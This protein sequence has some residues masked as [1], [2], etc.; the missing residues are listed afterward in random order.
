MQLTFVGTGG[1]RFTT[2]KQLRR[3]GGMHLEHDDFSLYIDPGP[4]ALVHA[5]D[6]DIALDA[7]DALLVTHAHL[8]HCND[9]NVLIEAMTDGGDREQGRLL[10][11]RT[12]IEGADLPD[13]FAKGDGTYGARIEPVLD[14]FHRGL[15][16]TV[17][18]VADGGRYDLGP[19]TVHTREMRHSDPHSI[20]FTLTADD[21]N[22]GFTGDTELFDGLIEFFRDCDVL[23]CNLMRP[24]EH[25][26]KGHLTTEDAAELLNAVEPDYAIMQ[27]FGSLFIY[28]S[29]AD[30]QSWLDSHTDIDV[31]F[32][33][34]GMTVDLEQPAQ[35]L[36]RF[37]S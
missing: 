8:D 2:I 10:A 29:V 3:T 33:K 15:L 27:H 19:F 9:M 34:D 26:W 28:E 12:V 30:Q 17:T 37:L 32:A 23:V 13:R 11:N 18:E 20:G 4:G 36:D 7:L 24:L 21:L 14:A 22:V 25:E 35:G 1:G 5:L 16:E 6:A 31:M